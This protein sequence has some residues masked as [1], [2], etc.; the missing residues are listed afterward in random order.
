MANEV[1]FDHVFPNVDVSEYAYLKEK[2]L[3]FG[4]DI[5]LSEEYKKINVHH[6]SKS[7]MYADRPI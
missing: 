2:D 1:D 6:V 4:D 7:K 5:I 3:S